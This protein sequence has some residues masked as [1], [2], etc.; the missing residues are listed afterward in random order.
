MPSSSKAEIV[1]K[2][3]VA[4]C[5]KMCLSCWFPCLEKYLDETLGTQVA[6]CLGYWHA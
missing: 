4:A 2:L 5:E 6:M 3:R 1:A